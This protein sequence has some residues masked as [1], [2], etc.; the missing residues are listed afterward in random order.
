[1][2]LAQY[3]LFGFLPEHSF[4]LLKIHGVI[5]FHDELYKKIGLFPP[6]KLDDLKKR[7][8]LGSNWASEEDESAVQVKVELICGGLLE[9]EFALLIRNKKIKRNLKLAH[10][11]SFSILGL[12]ASIKKFIF[13][14]S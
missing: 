1:M 5:F 11:H 6:E 8:R 9:K 2:A 14:S 4:N 12:M 13:K 7:F 3:L 10:S